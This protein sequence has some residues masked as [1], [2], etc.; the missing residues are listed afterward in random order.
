MAT[1]TQTLEAESP[2]RPSWFVRPLSGWWCALGWLVATGVFIGLIQLLGGPSGGDAFESIYATLAVA[3]G[4]L[5][6][7]YP[8]HPRTAPDFVAPMY[9]LVS[10]AL[11][12]IGQVGH[13]RAFPTSAALGP[14]CKHAIAVVIPW[15]V[16]SDAILPSLNVGYVVWL[17]LLTGA[18]MLLRASGRGRCGWE[19]TTVIGLAVLPPVWMGVEVYFHPQDLM[20]MGFGLAALACALRAQWAAAGVLVA[21]AVLTQQF[22]LLIAL[23]LLIVAPSRKRLPYV[24]GAAIGAVAIIVPLLVITSG[25]AASWIFVGTGNTP[26]QGGTWVW[27]LGLHGIPLVLLSRI[28]PLLLSAVISAWVVW[29]VREAALRPAVLIALV[30][31]SLSLRLVFEQNVFGY[32]Y[33]ALA[34]SLLLLDVVRGR[35]RDTMVAWQALVFIA[36]SEGVVSIVMWRQGWGQDARHWIP[37]VIMIAA[38]LVIIDQILRHQIRWNLLI[39]VGLVVGA[40]IVWPVSTNPLRH[41][42]PTWL[43]QVI[44]VSSGFLLAAV[45]LRRMVRDQAESPTSEPPTAAP[46]SVVTAG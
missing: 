46:E 28:L 36:Y 14:G 13:G 5:S 38:L 44:L 1:D 15:G 9:P 24:A 22:A 8:P 30:A 21:L 17:F 27:E 25:S 7:M 40:L 4:H 2:P 29:R 33:L 45:P 37:V 18:V 3:H 19:P 43:W 41:Q 32:Y 6:C 11:D 16:K 39:W 10:G 34:V 23:P 20:A 31:V 12:A 35:I 42:P 26:G